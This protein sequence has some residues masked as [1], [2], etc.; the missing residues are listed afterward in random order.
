MMKN[1]S[2]DHGSCK[3]GCHGKL[4]GVVPSAHINV[5][6]AEATPARQALFDH[7][8]S[9]TI[10]SMPSELKESSSPGQKFQYAHLDYTCFL[11]GP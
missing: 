9:G 3:H 10:K 4:C 11:C 2:I 6:T 1:A 7:Q 5:R 8:G